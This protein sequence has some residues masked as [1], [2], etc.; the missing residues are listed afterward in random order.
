M[1]KHSCLINQQLNAGVRQGQGTQPSAQI[2]RLGRAIND[3]SL[4]YQNTDDK[5]GR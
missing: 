2:H 4:T 5:P 3:K 1:L